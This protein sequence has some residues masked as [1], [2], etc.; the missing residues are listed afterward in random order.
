[1]K[2][3]FSFILTFLC[4]FKLSLQEDWKISSDE[5]MYLQDN[6]PVL[7]DKCPKNHS[8]CDKCKPFSDYKVNETFEKILFKS[9]KSKFYCFYEIKSKKDLK[10]IEN[11]E[12][13]I[14]PYKT[15]KN[16]LFQRKDICNSYCIPTA[17][18]KCASLNGD[19]SKDFDKKKNYY[20]P[21]KTE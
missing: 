17:G 15:F 8:K 11:S 12:K 13:F 9:N 4:L 20:C 18:K 10:K 21:I 2:K 19:G 6:K 14:K 1:M 3:I 16:L 7:F 5:L